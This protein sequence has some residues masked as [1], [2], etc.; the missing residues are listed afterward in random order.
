M[1]PKVP[2]E[3]QGR[4]AGT[5][6]HRQAFLALTGPSRLPERSLASA[7]SLTGR[8]CTSRCPPEQHG[9]RGT[10][11]Q[12]VMRSIQKDAIRPD[13][14]QHQRESAS[15]ASL[16]YSP[17]GSPRSPGPCRLRRAR[18]R[19]SRPAQ[20]CPCSCGSIARAWLQSPADAHPPRMEG[21]RSVEGIALRHE[22]IRVSRCLDEHRDPFRVAGIAEGSVH[23]L[24][25][26]RIRWGS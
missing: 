6:A 11:R 10:V 23:D 8:S 25:S 7:R 12:P 26:Q 4:A 15:R 13:Q 14:W 22:H 24:A 19:Q 1:P 3:L 2:T 9:A 5:D 16:P 18:R 20:E 17:A 21:H